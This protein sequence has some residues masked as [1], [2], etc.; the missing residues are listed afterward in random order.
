MTS[1]RLFETGSG[2][3]A[4][5]TTSHPF[6]TRAPR[7]RRRRWP[8]DASVVL[9]AVALIS[10]VSLAR[11][12]TQPPLPARPIQNVASAVVL[13]KTGVDKSGHRRPSATPRSKHVPAAIADEEPSTSAFDP[14]IPNGRRASL[15]GPPGDPSEAGLGSTVNVRGS[16]TADSR[17][18][19]LEEG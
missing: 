1:L 13:P 9:H 8:Y 10:M 15:Q 11:P 16:P 4:R 17:P 2:L 19:G 12:R 18:G 5:H 14:P 6:E 7:Y 3:I